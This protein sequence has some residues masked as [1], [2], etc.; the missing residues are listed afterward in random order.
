[1]LTRYWSVAGVRP[2]KNTKPALDWNFN[3]NC[4]HAVL[5]AIVCQSSINS[6]STVMLLPL[7][8]P[9]NHTDVF[10]HVFNFKFV[11]YYFSIK[12]YLSASNTTLSNISLFGNNPGEWEDVIILIFI[13]QIQCVTHTD[14]KKYSHVTQQCL[15]SQFAAHKRP[16]CTHEELSQWMR[17][18]HS[19]SF[20][21]SF[22]SCPGR[23]ELPA[24][25]KLIC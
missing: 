13:Q 3:L 2:G 12:T 10:K 9:I 21:Q 6:N 1:M 22:Y 14:E 17:V 19:L 24:I 8:H 25:S 18:W 5:T 23:V 15:T 4:F 11:R 7:T 20:P 16:M